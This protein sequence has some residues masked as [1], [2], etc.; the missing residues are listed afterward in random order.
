MEPI[1]PNNYHKPTMP[2][3]VPHEPA[4]LT[5]AQQR[6]YESA[7]CAEVRTM[8]QMIIDAPAC[9][10]HASRY[11]GGDT[12]FIERHIRYLSQRPG[13]NI[14]GYI[15]NLRIMTKRVR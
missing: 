3:A 1:A 7:E 9:S 8:L 6:F 10:T 14:D 13:I 11:E 15:S 5:H 12:E 4:V 2:D